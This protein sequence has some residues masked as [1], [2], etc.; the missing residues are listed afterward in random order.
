MENTV[1]YHHHTNLPTRST[2]HWCTVHKLP[3][4]SYVKCKSESCK[5]ELGRGTR[6]LRNH[7]GSHKPPPN[8][9]Y[10]YIL[11]NKSVRIGYTAIKLLCAPSE[12]STPAN[13]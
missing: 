12:A 5:P 3:Y 6:E 11:V 2:L 9:I 4:G 1:L 8:Y 7:L 13:R 10:M